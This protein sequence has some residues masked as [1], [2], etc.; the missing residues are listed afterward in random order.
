[1]LPEAEGLLRFGNM[2]EAVAALEGVEAD[3]ERHSHRARELAEELFD[4]EKVGRRLLEL[5]LT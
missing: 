4:G 1:V 2:D 5:A 3:Y